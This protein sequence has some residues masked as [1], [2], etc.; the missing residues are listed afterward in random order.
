MSDKPPASAADMTAA[1]LAAAL[2]DM[3]RVLAQEPELNGFGF[4]SPDWRPAQEH[5]AFVRE[6]R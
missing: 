2:A 3:E 5:D 1:K 6:Y 4:G